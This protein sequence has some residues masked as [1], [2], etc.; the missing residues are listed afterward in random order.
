MQNLRLFDERFT[1]IMFF[2]PFSDQRWTI[3]VK[4]FSLLKSLNPVELVHESRIDIYFVNQSHLMHGTTCRNLYDGSDQ[5][6][7]M[8]RLTASRN[9]DLVHATSMKDINWY[10]LH[11]KLGHLMT[12]MRE[13]KFLFNK[14][15]RTKWTKFHSNFTKQ[16][17]IFL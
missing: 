4:F 12:E 15:K 5:S 17:E 10:I 2:F 1:W 7:F 6:S 9:I 14:P 11:V 8:W 13:I 3:K 16:N